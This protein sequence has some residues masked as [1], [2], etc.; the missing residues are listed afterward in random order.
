MHPNVDHDSPDAGL[1]IPS[2]LP[3]L[4]VRD[5]VV[6][7]SMILPLYVGRDLSSHAVETA[8]EGDRLLVLVAQRDPEVEDPGPE[9]LYAVGTVGMVMRIMQLPEGRMKV[10]VQ[11]LAKV[12]VVNVLRTEPHIDVQ[13]EEVPAEPG[14]P[15][16]VEVEALLRAVRAKVEELLALRHLPPEIASVVAGVEDPGRMADLVASNLRLRVAEAQEV[17]EI[18]DGVRR[19]RKIDAILR[20][21]LAVSSVQAEIQ[22]AAREELSRSQREQFLREQLRAIQSELGETDEQ[23]AQLAEL[24]R[25]VAEAVMNDEARAEAERQIDRLARMHPDS[26]ETQVVRTYLEWMVELPW[27]RLSPDHFDLARARDV[28]E[29]DHAYLDRVKERVLEFLAVH[30]LRGEQGTKGPILCLVGPPGVGKTSLGRSVATAMGRKFV[31]I[32]LGGLRDEAE[33]RGHRR[34]YVG[35]LPGRILQGMRQAGESN[36]VFMLDEID[37]LGADYRGDP[38]AALL[39]VLDPEQNHHFRDHYLGVPYDL[40]RVLFIAT[41]NLV[42]PIPRALLDRTEVI[43][44]PGY[45]PEEKEEIGRRFLVPRQLEQCG[46]RPEQVRV[47]RAAVREVITRYTQEAGVRGLEREIG[48]ALRKIARRVAEQEIQ[49]TA[50]TTRNLRTYL[51][52]APLHDSGVPRREEVGIARGLAWTET[53]GE[54][55]LVE[56]SMVRGRDLILTGQL[57]DVMK[58][59]A[60][61]ALSWVRARAAPL[62][63]SELLARHEIHLHVPAGA[64]PKDGPSAGVTMATAMISLLSGV[65]VRADVA[66][67]GEITLRGRVLPVGGIREKA[68]AALRRGLR[69]VILPAANQPDLEEIPVELARR[70]RFCLVRDMDEALELALVSPLP[71]ARR[72]SART[73]KARAAQA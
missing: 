39:E 48:R 16:T 22:T 15:W 66:M 28:L 52:P 53:G 72:S 32:S 26:S 41:A 64:T 11:G 9:D 40:S 13:V 27:G 55:L 65:P 35:A 20:R 61:A 21:E 33:I 50:I 10:L 36:P 38:A 51:G 54:V 19:L 3:L 44:L 2:A 71:S 42:D 49:R 29:R 46:L 7:P 14:V 37:K 57:G 45:T 8:L 4:P 34:T 68:L 69:T 30:K 63:T 70:I 24:R 25:R 18:A 17:L 73:A 62:G 5:A 12:R 43:R 47:S 60:R 58:E 1:A 23:A 59:S 31:R 67:T 56:A 6:F